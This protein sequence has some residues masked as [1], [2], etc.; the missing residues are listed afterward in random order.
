MI[1]PADRTRQ[2]LVDAAV[3]VFAEKGYEGASVREITRKAQANQAA[4]TY[5]FGGKEGLYREV[6]RATFQAFKAFNLLEPEKLEA[7]EPQEALRLFVRQQLLP[8][9]KREQ[10]ARFIRILNWEVLQRTDAFQELVVSENTSVLPVAEGLVR[11]FL[12][13]DADPEAVAISTLWLLHQGFIFV[14]DYEHLGRAPL[15]FKLDDDFV[16]RLADL[17]SRLLTA[18]LSGVTRV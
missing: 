2:A 12:G 3:A 8:L 6:L 11:R 15:N 10:L 16:E 5:H 7:M 1:R 4:I 13:E 9:N 18:G 17:L 14:R